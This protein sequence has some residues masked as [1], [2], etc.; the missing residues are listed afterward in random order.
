MDWYIILAYTLAY[1]GL[2]ATSFYIIN[3]FFY[4]RLKKEPKEADDKTVSILI[5]AYNEEKS[6]E[7]TI[8]SVLDL[9]YP[10]ERIEIIVIDDGSKDRTYEIAKRFASSRGRK[11]KVLT[12]PNG[13]KA[14]ALNFGIERAKGEIVVSMDA[15]TFVRPDSL[16]KMIGFFT[17]RDIM[18]VSPSMGVYRPR[19]LWGRIVQIEYYMGVF[20][21]KSFATMNAIHV[22]PGAFSAYRKEFFLKY[23][24]YQEGNITEDLEV[25]LRIQSNHYII[26][27]APKAV[28]YTLSPE[29]F[30]SLLYQRRRWYVG[31]M[32]NLWAYRRLFGFKHGPLGY[33]VLPVA[34]STILLSVSLTIYV[35]VRALTEAWNEVASLSTINF[36]FHNYF[37]VNAFFFES[38]FFSIFSRPVFVISILFLLLLAF[39]IFFSKKQMKYR[40]GVVLNFIL[41]VFL[42][43]LLFT[44]W[45]IVA[46]VYLIFNKKVAWREQTNAKKT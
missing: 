29:S 34:I 11:V 21:R 45:W 27:N 3:L 44:F 32:K 7:R 23:G 42:Y 22:T 36:E 6:I 41:F 33:I 16:K 2:L 25:A 8:K 40:D 20:L 4:Y 26:Q 35:I 38:L 43:S 37:E 24:G 30:K 39:Y 10:D 15:D 19:G 31:L 46:F 17:S 13:G 5:P 9:E 18:C 28:A 12:K 14:S 1:I